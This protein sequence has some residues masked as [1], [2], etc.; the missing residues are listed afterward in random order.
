MYQE[1]IRRIRELTGRLNQWRHEYYNLN[2]PMVTDAEYDSAF[3]ELLALEI[4]AGFKMSNSP[5]QTVGYVP[6]SALAKVTHPAPL[7]S[8]D[9]TKSI[10]ELLRFVGGRPALLMLKLDG[11]TIKLEYE[12]GCLAR[13][14]TRGDGNVGEDITHNARVF[15]NIPLVVPYPGRLA[16]TGEALITTG[17]FEQL[18]LELAGSDGE[19][20]KTPRNLAAGS[21]RLFDPSECAKR[22][23]HFYAFPVLDGPDVPMPASGGAPVHFDPNSKKDRLDFLKVL[24]FDTCR[25]FTLN[26]GK[27]GEAPPKMDAVRLD[28]YIASLKGYAEQMGLPIDGMVVTFDDIG[29]SRSLGATGHHYKDGLAFKFGDEPV[30]TVFRGI[31]W[32]P[33][34]FGEISPVAVFDTVEIDGCEVTRASLHNLSFIKELGLVSGCRILVTKRNMI[35]PH[36]EENLDAGLAPGIVNIGA[37]P[38]QY[39]EHWMGQLQIC[40]QKQRNGECDGNDSTKSDPNV[41]C[42]TM[43][44]KKR[45]RELKVLDELYPPACPCCGKPT[46]VDM[47]GAAETLRCDNP[48]CS[49]QRLRQFVHFVGKK[50]MDIEGLSEATLERFIKR[51]WLKEFMD[52]YRLDRHAREI[53]RMDGFGEKSWQRLWSAIEASRNT[54]FERYLVAMDIPMVGRTASRE[55][56]RHFAGDL[57]AFETAVDNGYDFTQLPD[58]GETLHRNIHAWVKNEDN[59]NIWEELQKMLNIETKTSATP[60]PATGNPFAGRTVVVTGKLELFTREGI[61]TRILELGGKPG[62][63]VSKNTDYLICGEAAGSKLDKARQLGVPVLTEQQFLEMVG[64]AE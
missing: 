45:A 36:V 3:D 24:G 34:R 4:V 63:A 19:L 47:G 13:A 10:E 62:S 22:R 25:K 11:L 52:V 1:Q 41:R 28:G 38:E 61:N 12:N 20:Y 55:L 59:R 9:K 35:I 18:R 14:S 23:I 43:C 51:G 31:E 57:N 60:A 58:F 21:V 2:A 37:V 42:C 26:I 15:Q 56:Y 50:A 49:T 33:T 16:I 8:L 7:L 6:V 30:E 44:A 27:G 40:A 5:T 48:D 29:Y 39:R 54:T 46:R 53:Q 64:Q 32:T 17:D